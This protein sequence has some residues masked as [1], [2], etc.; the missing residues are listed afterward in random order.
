MDHRLT[1]SQLACAKTCLRKH[2][3]VYVK[4]IRVDHEAMPLRMGKAFHLGL[5]QKAKGKSADDAILSAVATY[6]QA[7][8]RFRDQEHETD[9]LVERE[10]VSCLLS[11]YF[12]RWA[13]MDAAMRVIASECAFEMPLMNPET[14]R[15]SR[16]FVYAGRIDKVV[17]LPDGRLAV[18]EHKTSGSDL[19]PESDYWKRLRIDSQIS[20]YCL[21]ARSLGH[22]VE[23]VLY[24]VTRKPSIRLKKT[25]TVAQYS[26]R[27][28]ADI[29]ERPDWYFARREIPRLNSDLTEAAFDLWQTAQIVG[30]C[31]RLNRWP[32]NTSS[33]IGFGR[34]SHFDLC[35]NGYDPE[36]PDV[37]P[38]FMRVDDAHQELLE[39]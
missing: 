2:Q 10:I 22:A 12:W 5:D 35:T 25:E 32:R 3:L 34:C 19:A 24:D 4:G 30:D 39:N 9:W 16:K 36:S 15:A 21:G 27:L 28:I 8:P 38:G 1:N 20:N 7:A 17:A 37:P 14:G 26:E 29:G 6:D 13:E 18:M 11:A 31:D 33:C 23:T